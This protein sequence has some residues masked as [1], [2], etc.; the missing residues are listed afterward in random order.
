MR[1]SLFLLF[2]LTLLPAQGAGQS[3]AMLLDRDDA[4]DL[5]SVF[6]AL[7]RS[8]DALFQAREAVDTALIEVDHALGVL[9][10]T[11]L[12]RYS[13]GAQPPSL[14]VE[15]APVEVVAKR[16]WLEAAAVAITSTRQGLNHYFALWQPYLEDLRWAA[17]LA[18]ARQEALEPGEAPAEGPGESAEGIP[19][20]V[21]FREEDL[22]PVLLRAPV[23]GENALN[24]A[25]IPQ[26]PVSVPSV[27]TDEATLERSDQVVVSPAPMPSLPAATEPALPNVGV[28]AAVAE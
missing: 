23:R 17:C 26:P 7:E 1:H 20:A 22:C 18:H 5:A 3:V 28:T 13:S 24:V 6:T 21:V 16:S 15:P 11:A 14:W 2:T 19:A 8:R 10:G 4:R 12:A 9:R 27:S 25:E